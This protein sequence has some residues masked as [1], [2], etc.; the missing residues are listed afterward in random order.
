MALP[1]ET[2]QKLHDMCVKRGLD[3][4]V[5]A[6]KLFLADKKEEEHVPE[7]G[8]TRSNVDRKRAL[9]T[10]RFARWKIRA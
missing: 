2:I 6:L 4:K 9:R 1:Q 7:T 3:R 10:T 5:E 8:K